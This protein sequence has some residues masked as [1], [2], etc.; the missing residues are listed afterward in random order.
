M[1]WPEKIL[2]LVVLALV[3]ALL[4]LSNSFVPVLD[5]AALVG[6]VLIPPC[7]FRMSTGIACPTCF[8][9]RSFALMARGRVI[10]AA[11]LQPMGALLWSLLALSVPFLIIALFKTGSVWPLLE[12]SPWKR[13]FL[14]LFLLTL[15]SWGYTI[16][17]DLTGVSP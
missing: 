9:T 15:A 11:T 6:P 3:V 4:A 13:I 2:I 1:Y 5:H 10:E 12:R 14:V 17:R 8:M 7:G 16:A